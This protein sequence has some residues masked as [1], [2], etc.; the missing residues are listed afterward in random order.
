MGDS[1]ADAKGSFWKTLPG[2]LSAIGG[3]LVGIGAIVTAILA[4]NGRDPPQAMNST[5]SGSTPRSSATAS[6]PASG[7]T[8]SSVPPTTIGPLTRA[9]LAKVRLTVSDLPPG[10]VDVAGGTEIWPCNQAPVPARTATSGDGAFNLPSN[11][12]VAGFAYTRL[13]GYATEDDAKA[14]LNLLRS[15][16]SRCAASVFTVPGGSNS[17]QFLPTTGPPFGDDVAHFILRDMDIAT[18]AASDALVSFI[19]WGRTLLV[20]EVAA[21]GP[22]SAATDGA[23][24]DFV[25]RAMAR[26]QTLPK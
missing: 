4:L 17:F 20:A 24:L 19:R 7:G 18:G 8:P 10:W 3:L 25:N 16:G 9:D 11:N 22:R 23:Q 1:S 5:G 14:V 15:T 13:D 26:I 21:P 12:V 2:V 6:A